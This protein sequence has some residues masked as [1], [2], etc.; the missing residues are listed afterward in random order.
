MAEILH[1]YSHSTAPPQQSLASTA[2]FSAETP[3][4][5]LTAARC[6]KSTYTA[7]EFFV[8]V[9]NEVHIYQNHLDKV[10]KTSKIEEFHINSLSFVGLLH[11]FRCPDSEVYILGVPPSSHNASGWWR[12]VRDPTTRNGDFITSNAGCW[13]V[14]WFKHVQTIGS[15]RPIRIQDCNTWRAFFLLPFIGVPRVANHQV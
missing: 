2:S 11:R 15:P 5:P 4:S 12:L 9:G 13:L 3:L 7:W 14:R 1:P 6:R 8:L 10:M